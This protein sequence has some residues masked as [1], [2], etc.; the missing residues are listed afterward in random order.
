MKNTIIFI[1]SPE[2]NAKKSST[3]YKNLFLVSPNDVLYRI[4]TSFVPPFNKF[5]KIYVDVLGPFICLVLLC[6]FL[7][8]GYSLKPHKIDRSPFESI[9]C[10]SVIMPILSYVLLKLG[11][12]SISFWE[13][14]CVFGYSLYGHLFT[15]FLS[16]IFFQETSDAMFFI[17]LILVGGPSTLRLILVYLKTIPVPGAR[18]LICSIVSIGNILFLIYLYFAFLHRNYMY[19]QT[20]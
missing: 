18:L 1:G 11:Q 12:S 13:T 2:H 16:Y 9:V 8:Y 6:F 5:R 19:S 7:N 17:S 15:L 3:D 14:L 4:F 10:F 20:V